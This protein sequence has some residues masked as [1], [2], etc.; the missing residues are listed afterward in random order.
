M[1]PAALKRLLPRTLLERYHFTLAL[2][3]AFVYGFP[4]RRMLVIG[5]TGTDGK[6]TVVHLLHDMLAASGAAVGS[7][8]SLRFKIGEKEEPNLL[9]MTMPGRFRLQ[10]FLAECRAAG[11]RYA[12]IEVTSQGIAQSRHRFIRFGAAILTNVTPEHIEA[13]GGFERYRAA[14]A[15]LFRRLAPDGTAVLNR[16]DPS[17]EYFAA[18]A[19]AEISWYSRSEI[20]VGHVGHPVRMHTV[21]PHRL[22]L[23]IDGRLIEAGLGGEFNVMNVLAAAAAA[24]ALGVSLSAI[25]SALVRACAIAGRLEYVQEEPFAVVVDYANT[26][27]AYR[28]LY[29]ALGRDLICVFGAPGGGRDTWKRPELG[30]IAAE[31]CRAI[32]LT[33]DDPDEEDPARIADAIRSGLAAA[34]LAATEFIPDRR[35]AIRAALASARPGDTVIITGMGA[36]PWLVIG[37][38]K[39]PWDDRKVVRE[40]LSALRHA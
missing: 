2:L 11:C 26:P 9:K 25:A 18:A 38:K 28:A 37:G 33:S 15:E 39:I 7:L 22:V 31:F 40:E 32:F 27:A 4:S 34:K 29:R 10:R 14:K 6:T 35:L 3:A 16:E 13:H 1:I 8:S 12:V 23:E 17:A 24:L 20:E 19:P 36:Q 21:S 5:V 30:K